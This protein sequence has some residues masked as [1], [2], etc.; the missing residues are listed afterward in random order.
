MEKSTNTLGE[1]NKQLL[2]Q[3]KEN[4]QL[5]STSTDLSLF[6]TQTN[7]SSINSGPKSSELQLLISSSN[8]LDSNS[9]NE[10]KKKYD[11]L[12]PHLSIINQIDM[13]TL[14]QERFV[15]QISLLRVPSKM[16][17]IFDLD[18][19]LVCTRPEYFSDGKVYELMMRP[20]IDKLFQEI[21]D[22]Y[23]IWVWSASSR[24]Y[25]VDIVHL[26][27]PMSKYISVILSL[28]DCSFVSESI[29]IK[30]LAIMMN[31]PL[32][33]TVIID[34]LLCSFVM[35]PSNGIL[36][37]AFIGSKDDCELLNVIELLKL[38]RDCQDVRVMLTE[39]L[40]IE[41]FLKEQK[42]KLT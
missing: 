41:N 1:E 39:F 22:I 27:D 14:E 25:V 30:D 11:Y 26:I 40:G 7:N 8:S 36:V 4:L 38:L 15:R 9:S 12:M 18:E 2:K 24:E 13:N 16:V 10:C 20:F 42:V 37:E 33:R 28:N 34:N 21:S 6:F 17:A 32:E 23:E 19:T 31:L 5:S 35:Q 3:K 29:L